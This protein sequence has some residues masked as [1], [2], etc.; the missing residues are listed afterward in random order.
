MSSMRSK[1]HTVAYPCVDQPLHV[2]ALEMAPFT[3]PKSLSQSPPCPLPLPPRRERG[4]LALGALGE[5]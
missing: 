1:F 4:H 3:S 5:R 2:M